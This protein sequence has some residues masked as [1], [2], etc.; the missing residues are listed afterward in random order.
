MRYE[1][2]LTESAVV[3]ISPQEARDHDMFGPMYHGTRGDISNILATGFNAKH[4]V[5]NASGLSWMSRPVGTSNGMPLEGYG[6]TGIA[7]P[8]HWLGFGTY[9]TTVKAIA[10]QFAGGSTKGMKTFYLASDRVA[11][12]NF[13]SPRTMMQWWRENG[14]DM[15]AEAT[16]AYDVRAWIKATG[17]LTRTLRQQYDA[18]WYKG[19]SMFKMLDGDQVCIYRPK[20]LRVIDPKLAT[21]LQI[22]AKVTHTQV[23]PE[24]YRGSNVFYVDDFKQDD[25]GSPGKSAGQGWRGIYRADQEHPARVGRF[26]VHRIPPPGMV[27]TIVDQRGNFYDV[28]WAKGGIMY[29]YAPEELQPKT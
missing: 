23:I 7:A 22:G 12:I 24:R 25:F 21:G 20:L 8:I 6:F 27:G 2:L 14:Y 10:K 4:S 15:T 1:D 9:M 28:K 19:K 13:G 16:K 18:V 26:P 3:T 11:E 29:N 5:P 17:N